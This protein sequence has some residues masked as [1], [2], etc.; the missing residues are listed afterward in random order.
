MMTPTRI[1]RFIGIV[2]LI[3]WVGLVGWVGKTSQ[4]QNSN[5]ASQPANPAVKPAPAA[6]DAP[7]P[8]PIAPAA[9]SAKENS[10]AGVVHKDQ[11]APPPIDPLPTTVEKAPAGAEIVSKAPSIALMD[12]P[13][14][15]GEDPEK[16]AQSFVER[17]RKEAEVQLKALTTEAEQL[18][19]RL[20]KL[21]SGIKKWH[22]LL[23]ALKTAEQG[24]A[25][26]TASPAGD[27]ANNQEQA[28]PGAGGEKNDKR[29]KWASASN[30]PG[31]PVDPAITQLEPAAPG[32]PAAAPALPQVVPVG[33]DD[34]QEHKLSIIQAL[35]SIIKRLI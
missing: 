29:V 32:Q 33:R 18:R 8:P 27:E 28:K 23:A 11:G 1:V 4:A 19:T 14:A 10:A 7:P 13:A 15:G 26:V 12:A 9:A 20:A 25:L 6:K 21:D 34:W 31:A 35:G 2:G 5:Q 16:S 22:N 17:N 30:A 24:Q 3:G